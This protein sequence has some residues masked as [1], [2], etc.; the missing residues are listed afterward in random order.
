VKVYLTVLS[1]LNNIF[2]LFSKRLL[3]IK[4]IDFQKLVLVFRSRKTILLSALVCI[5]VGAFLVAQ[6]AQALVVTLDPTGVAS[7]QTFTGS[8][9]NV[10]GGSSPNTSTYMTTG[11]NGAAGDYVEFSMADQAGV[12]SGTQV[13]FYAYVQSIV[14]GSQYDTI[15][16]EIKNGATTIASSSAFTT[17]G[18]FA[19]YTVT[20]DGSLSQ[21]DVNNLRARI[22]RTVANGNGPG[23][24]RDDEIRLAGVYM[25]LT[26]SPAYQ[27]NQASYRWFNNAD[28]VTT[29][30][31]TF[32]KL[33]N[34]S[35]LPGGNSVDTAFSPDSQYMTVAYGV[36]PYISIYKRSGD[37]FTK[38][39]DPASPP[40]STV[41][42][43]AWSPDG[44]YLSVAHDLHP[45]ITIYKR[46]GDTFTKLPDPSSL[47]T[48]SGNDATW[49]PD[50]QYLSVAHYTSP[51]LTIYKRSGDTFNKLTNPTSLPTGDA[52]DVS[53]SPDGQYMSIAYNASP[54][55]SVY[56]R[57]GDTFTKLSSPTD[58]PPSYSY[59]TTFSPDGQYM[60]V[61]HA[62]SPYITIYKRS[63]DTFTK[64]ANPT[65]LPTSSGFATDFSPG[66]QY[67]SV[68]HSAS[69]YLTIYKRSGDT[70]TKVTNPTGLPTGDGYGTS[71]SP[72]GQY[73]SVAHL[74]SPFITIYKAPQGS[75]DVGT[76]LTTQ[77]TA[78]N[79]PTNGQFR[80]RLNLGVS[81]G[82]LAAAAMSYRLQYAVRGADNVCDTSFTNE[83]YADVTTSTAISYYN[84]AIA[85]DG[86][87]LTA[88]ANDP[89]NGS[90]PLVRQTYEESNNFEISNAIAAGSTGMWDFSL[91]T[92]PSA[93][94]GTY[95]LR[96]VKADGSTLSSY[97]VV[98][99]ITIT[100]STNQAAYR[101]FEN[102]D[103]ILSSDTFTKVSNLSGGTP[104]TSTSVAWSSD[105]QYMAVGAISGSYL[106]IYKRSG[107]TLT[108]LSEPSAQPAGEVNGV[109]FSP[110]GM[111]L[112]VA[113]SSYPYITIYKRSG[114]TFTELVT[115]T[116]LPAGDG[117]ASAFSSDGTYMSVAHYYYPYI[118]IY[119]RSGDT[120]TKLADPT[121]LP[122]GDS[123]GIAFSSD[124]TYMSV[125][126]YYSPYIT[127]YKRSG[128]T[129]T[130]LADPIDLPANDS[131]GTAFSPDGTYMSVAHYDYP[132]LTIYK[133]SGD[134]FTKLSDPTSLPT[135]GGYSIA[136]SPDGQYLR[137][138]HSSS[139]YITIYKRSGDTFTKLSDP[140]SLPSSAGNDVAF[141]PDGQYLS[142]VES[143]SPYINI[144]KKSDSIGLGAPLAST[145]V[146]ATVPTAGT[147]FRL[148]AAMAV[149]GAMMSPGTSFK[150]QFALRGSDNVCDAS[151]TNETYADVS[152]G[153]AVKFYDNS[154]G[155]DGASFSSTVNDPAISGATML[156]QT[157]EESN[158]FTNSTSIPSGSAGLWDFALTLDSTAVN[159]KN[160]CLRI[161][162][163][164]GSS[165]D[166]YGAIAEIIVP[167]PLGPDLSQQMRGGQ[168]VVNGMK[169][170][171]SW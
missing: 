94:A 114:D 140:A 68:S 44:Q 91:S 49:S 11:T 153:T 146:A 27:V 72:D 102:N 57:S 148:R 88:N 59:G 168:G 138:V 93:V 47:P 26:Y 122:T 145:N 133:R 37:T 65:N 84:N 45:F 18:S 53:F 42:G 116:S 130:K 97:S 127:I 8:Y 156:T 1:R 150:L 98:P 46:S 51:Y 147:S 82:N 141:S 34:P 131:V 169:F 158:P 77:N 62:S 123:F 38:L 90:S 55:L 15:S 60:S 33:A 89:T 163:S 144:Y 74:T 39:P 170:P 52:N 21:T 111:Y 43:T 105:G 48:G 159:N 6:N 113:Q 70:F 23:N 101:L 152:T 166:S 56:K 63:G 108:R 128:D 171:F 132:Y 104:G 64:L 10:L 160:Y 117:N 100:T 67:M 36:Y 40:P 106:A 24:S 2:Q 136:F 137:V 14:G 151:A 129:F 75:V 80:L 109:A 79:M 13:V 120:F 143:A 87:S 12:E 83:T 22:T 103:T 149:S 135:G 31:D 92:G 7:S 161:V 58:L 25:S 110:D 29:A 125:A 3:F 134:T 32:T 69:P 99:Q 73:M 71:F 41:V 20:Y 142:V 96:A 86:Y 126:H 9:T 115:P 85:A 139:P 5:L 76:S 154:A 112:S 28:T 162:S 19:W 66:G 155:T 78:S 167:A 81:G 17:T 50:G 61:A 119:K 16:L 30:N 95:C 107:D 165:L 124:G 54:F 157:Y 35:V 164:A 4:S 118:T 121:S